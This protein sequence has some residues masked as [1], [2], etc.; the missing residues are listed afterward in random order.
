VNFESVVSG[1]TTQGS[2]RGCG[3]AVGCKDSDFAARFQGELLRRA[4]SLSFTRRRPGFARYCFSGLVGW[5]RGLRSGRVVY[6][7]FPGGLNYE[8]AKE[9]I[10]FM[11][12][13][14]LPV[15]P[16]PVALA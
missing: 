8:L 1:Y 6:L 9:G 7:A 4:A 13:T 15:A 3:I 11:P 12:D 14:R 10:T 5:W 2:G 16:R